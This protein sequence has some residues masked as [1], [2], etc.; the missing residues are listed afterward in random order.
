MFDRMLQATFRFVNGI[1]KDIA[2]INEN[3]VPP[4]G[5]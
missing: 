5:G 2:P 3:P 4:D 1:L